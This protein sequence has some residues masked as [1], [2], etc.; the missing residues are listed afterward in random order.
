[1]SIDP[2]SILATPLPSIETTYSEM[3]TMRYALSIGMGGN[4]LDPTEL[5]F[6]YGPRLRSFP[7]MALSL[8][9]V[10]MR[11]MALGIDYARMVQGGLQLAVHHPL[12]VAGKV[13]A[14]HRVTD[15]VDLGAERGALLSYE[16]VLRDGGTG[17]LLA[18]ATMTAFCRGDGGF[19]GP[20]RST[21]RPAA[22]PE[23]P[24]DVVQEMPTF[25]QQAL[26]YRLAGDHAAL[27]ADPQEARRVGFERPIL[28]G[29]ASVGLIARALTIRLAQGDET[30]LQRIGGRFSKPIYPGET[31]VVQ[32]WRSTQPG[33]VAL[34][35]LC[36][37]R[38]TVVFDHGHAVLSAQSIA[39]ATNGQ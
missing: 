36:K 26:L 31:L 23:G 28:Q 3:D 20:Q 30:R 19:G 22:M 39:T 34:R 21:P 32:M 13:V 12:P 25:A 10:S 17:A 4:P 5:P 18:T 7:T 37:E 8:G 29:I 33:Q 11:D 15:C 24:A 16:R 6:V 14:H 1:M 35:A 9:Y 2:A 38:G 27:H